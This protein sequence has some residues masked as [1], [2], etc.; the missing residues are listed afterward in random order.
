MLASF[1]GEGPIHV[2]LHPKTQWMIDII[3]CSVLSLV[4]LFSSKDLIYFT[5][6]IWDDFLSNSAS[7]LQGKKEIPHCWNLSRRSDV[8]LH[9]MTLSYSYIYDYLSE[10]LLCASAICHFF[11]YFF[12]YAIKSERI[13]LASSSD[14]YKT[15]DGLNLTSEGEIY[16]QRWD[17]CR[18]LSV[19]VRETIIELTSEGGI[20]VQRWDLCRELSLK[21]SKDKNRACS[22]GIPQGSKGKTTC[23]DDDGQLRLL[24]DV[25]VSSF[26][27]QAWQNG[28][29]CLH[30]ARPTDDTICYIHVCVARVVLKQATMEKS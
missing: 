26:S 13:D 17:L 4:L 27:A 8:L 11:L 29:G 15:S 23:N 10:P 22:L 1:H 12:L 18:E 28:D 7:K 25:N 5:P 24:P 2:N 20:Y 16:V 3:Y 19:R 6:F 9:T 21:V 14:Y 30:S